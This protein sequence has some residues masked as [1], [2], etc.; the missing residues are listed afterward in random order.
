VADV[1]PQLG[2]SEASFCLWRKKYA[3]LG[4]TEIREFRQL[5]DENTRLKRLVTRKAPRAIRTAPEDS[6][7]R[8]RSA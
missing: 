2:V 7:D 1:F 6:P 3:K 8:A 4:L 5:R